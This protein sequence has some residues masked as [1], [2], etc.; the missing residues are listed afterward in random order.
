MH[1][2]G[3]RQL[4]RHVL[5]RAVAVIPVQPVRAV[6]GRYKQ[7]HVSVIVYVTPGD[8]LGVAIVNDARSFGN[9][10]ERAVP[11]VPKELRRVVCTAVSFVTHIQIEIAITVIVGK[12]TGLRRICR[13]GESR[14]DGYI[15]KTA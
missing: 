15:D 6:V 10:G 4:F 3:H 12:R 1:R 7:V 14:R 5:E 11:I 13:I 2:P 8:S 9:V